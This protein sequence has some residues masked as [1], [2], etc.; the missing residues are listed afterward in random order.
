[1]SKL[2]LNDLV[3]LQN[4]TTAVSNINANNAL[5]EAAIE[6]TLSRDGTSPNSMNAS[7]DMNSHTILNLPSPT[8]DTE[9]VTLGFGT[10]NYGD[11]LTNSTAAAASAT[12]AA[13][14]A[15]SA[16]SSATSSALSATAAAA[17]AASVTPLPS[18]VTAGQLLRSTGSGSGSTWSTLIVPNTIPAGNILAAA[19]SNNVAATATPTLG[20]SGTLGSVTM[21]NATSGTVTLRPVTGAL[22]SVTVS[23]PAA[24]DTLVGKA[25]TDTLTNKTID[26]LSAANVIKINGTS[27]T[28]VSGT[29]GSTLALVNGPAFTDATANTQTAGN[30]ST[31]LATTAYVDARP[32][33][34]MTYGATGINCNSAN[35]D[36]LVTITFPPGFTKYQLFRA[37]AY[38]PS[39]SLTTATAGIYTAA[40]AGGFNLVTTTALSPLTTNAVNTA[41]ASMTFTPNL[42]TTGYLTSTTL[43]FRIGTAQG[44]AATVDASFQLLF[45]P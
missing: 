27:V 2:T 1:L 25:T 11:S 45:F 29:S 34:M 39:T 31:K 40:A 38:N 43:Y 26:T 17:S 16:S 8:T 20:A 5:I 3:N 9:P 14:S 28:N 21:G 15:T 12:A 24:T 44:S 41:G 7:L 35:T 4:E 30:N 19:T 13:A 18:T 36:N 23:L 33:I 6:N 37:Y 42:S 22:G 32:V 10:A